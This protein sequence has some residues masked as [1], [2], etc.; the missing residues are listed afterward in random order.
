MLQLVVY[1]FYYC[2][3]SNSYTAEPNELHEFATDKE[4]LLSMLNGEL[5]HTH[6][7]GSHPEN[8]FSVVIV[9]VSFM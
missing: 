8:V 4:P 1:P 7:Q 2:I 9:Y 5:Y 6:K 3:I